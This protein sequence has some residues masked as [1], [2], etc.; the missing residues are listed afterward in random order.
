MS[1]WEARC[2]ASVEGSSLGPG[3]ERGS[4]GGAGRIGA[5]RYDIS[6][7]SITFRKQ[8]TSRSNSSLASSLEYDWP[9]D[10]SP[11]WVFLLD[12]D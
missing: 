10:K 4:N 5:R 7:Y 1:K 9:S 2:R 3:S 11:S 12:L 8:L 6:N